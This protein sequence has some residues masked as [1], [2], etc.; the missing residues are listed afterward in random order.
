MSVTMINSAIRVD[1]DIFERNVGLL[2]TMVGATALVFSL[3]GLL[4]YHTYLMINNL[5][6]LEVD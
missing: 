6:T 2:I 1:F 4:G 3:G 5:S